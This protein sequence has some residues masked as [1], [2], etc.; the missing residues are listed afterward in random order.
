MI[1]TVELWIK[2][3]NVGKGNIIECK[4]NKYTTRIILDLKTKS[5]NVM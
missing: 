1:W 5:K 3:Y 2:T 4:V